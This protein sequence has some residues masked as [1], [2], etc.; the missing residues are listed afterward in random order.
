MKKLALILLSALS[1]VFFVSCS[2][3]N[4]E[5]MTD[6]DFPVLEDSRENEEKMNTI[7]T[8]NGDDVTY[9]MNTRKIVCIF[10]SQDV[11]GFGIKLLAYE[12]TTDI[13][14]YEKFYE[15]SQALNDIS[16]FSVEEVMSYNPELILV[17]Q[18]MSSDNIKSLKTIAPVIPLYTESN[19][20][21]IRLNYIGKIFGLEESAKK[22]VD[23]ASNLRARMLNSI[24]S[25][26][27]SD[28]TIT[29]YTYMGNVTIVPERGWFMNVI[30]Y[31]YLGMKRKDNVILFMQ[32]ESSIAYQPISSEKIKDYE[33][34]LVIF[35]GFGETSISTYVSENVGWKRL[36]AVIEDRVGVIDITPYAQKGV[37]LLYNQYSQILNALTK[38]KG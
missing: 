34:D 9:N 23:Y 17:N 18:K 24:N 20:F 1:I 38:A 8:L 16:P 27:L 12:G 14:G 36:K 33:G 32:D 26:G 10:G 11:V 31:D 6:D 19:D 30:I 37:I 29:I 3:N 28:K 21:S 2:S 13:T 4:I 35:A 22:L 7:T 5:V 25:L 15:G